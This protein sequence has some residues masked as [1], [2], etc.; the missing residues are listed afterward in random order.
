LRETDVPETVTL[1]HD[2]QED[3]YHFP[4]R[5]KELT[6]D[7][8]SRYF[9]EVIR[10]GADLWVAEEG[11]RIL[12]YLALKGSY[13]DRLYV[14]PEAQRKGVG[15]AL[16]Q[17]AWELSPAGLELHTHQENTKA[18]RF[19]EKYGFK[20]VRFGISPPPESAPDVEY[21]WRPQ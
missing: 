17:K 11:Q 6:L 2:T 14:R 4:A 10:P 9:R 18:R 16:L 8:S 15:L 19:Y 12:G 21:H 13:L 1:W 7:D 5:E 3:T 20:A